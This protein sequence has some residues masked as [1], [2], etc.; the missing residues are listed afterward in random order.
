MDTKTC[1]ACFQSIDSR[2]LR[3]SGCGTR[4][5]DAPAMHRDVP[6]RLLGGVCASI[7]MQFGWDVTLVRAVLVAS[8]AFTAGMGVW[9]YAILWLLTPFEAQGKSPAHKAMDAVGGLFRTEAPTNAH[10]GPTDL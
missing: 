7:A 6:G 5:P 8:L 4:Q 10:T 2:A 1:P 9:L 3:C